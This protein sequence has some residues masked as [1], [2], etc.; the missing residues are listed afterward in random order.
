MNDRRLTARWDCRGGTPRAPRLPKGFSTSRAGHD[1]SPLREQAET[2]SLDSERRIELASEVF[3]RNCRGQ[4]DDLR[5]A[6][7]SRAELLAVPF[8]WP[9]L[10]LYA[11]KSG[12]II[13]GYITTNGNRFGHFAAFLETVRYPTRTQ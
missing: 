3:E 8:R 7:P 2:L 5:L 6:E 1:L 9:F 11:G 13:P 12:Q 4:L 10:T